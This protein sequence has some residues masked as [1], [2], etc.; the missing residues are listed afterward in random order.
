MPKDNRTI[1]NGI[2][3]AGQVFTEGQEDDLAAA[4]PQERL[5][6]LVADGALSGDWV[7]S[8]AA[9]KAKEETKPTAKTETK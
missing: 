7:A 6:Q 5:D 2:R 4:L 8:K 9:A 3:H 1:I